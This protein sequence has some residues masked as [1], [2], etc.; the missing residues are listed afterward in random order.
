[1]QLIDKNAAFG[2]CI[3]EGANK[4]AEIIGRLPPADAVPVIHCRDC[5][6]DGMSECPL[7]WIENHTMQFI[8]HDPDF[9]CGKGERREED[10]GKL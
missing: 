5:L 9:F 8:N 1:M 4:A 7:C 3:M 2:I 6:H 10:N